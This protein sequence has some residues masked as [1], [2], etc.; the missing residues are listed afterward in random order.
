MKKLILI[1][2]GTLVC[3][4][5]AGCSLNSANPSN[6]DGGQDTQLSQNQ[7]EEAMFWDKNVWCQQSDG[8]LYY[9][10][11][12]K[13]SDGN[14]I[15]DFDGIQMWYL[16]IDKCYVPMTDMYDNVIDKVTTRVPMLYNHEDY[17]RDV[18]KVMQCLE[19]S[20]EDEVEEALSQLQ[21]E[22]LDLDTIIQLYQ[23]LSE[24]EYH[25]DSGD[26]SSIPFTDKLYC[27]L[28]SQLENAKT[29]SVTYFI[30]YGYLAAIN[31]EILNDDEEPYS[32]LL[33][34]NQLDEQAVETIKILDEIEEYIAEEQ[35]LDISSFKDKLDADIY[36]PLVSLLENMMG[37]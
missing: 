5:L 18:D 15:Y 10:M 30:D 36:Y 34:Q 6:A 27:E 19:E 1:L 20:E 33:E 21:L 8:W 28:D 35:N 4:Y 24:K 23:Q 7:T 3:S 2:M 32:N 37:S 12:S 14:V 11:A 31:I 17:G 29:L 9:M 16:S 25:E 22:Y 26:F 13:E